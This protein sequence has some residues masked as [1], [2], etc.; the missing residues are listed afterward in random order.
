MRVLIQCHPHATPKWEVSMGYTM[1]VRTSNDPMVV[2]CEASDRDELYGQMQD[3]S[4]GARLAIGLKQR[5]D[6]LNPLPCQKLLSGDGHRTNDL[7]TEDITVLDN[8]LDFG[9]LMRDGHDKVLRPDG[10]LAVG[11]DVGP[12]DGSIGDLYGDVGVAGHG[13]AGHLAAD[14][15]G[16]ARA[17]ELAD[18]LG[19]HV[20]VGQVA[21]VVHPDVE[22][23]VEQH[24]LE[25]RP[26][27]PAV[28]RPSPG[29][30]GGHHLHPAA[31]AA[32]APRGR[33]VGHHLRPAAREGGRGRGH[34]GRRRVVVAV[35]E[36]H[37][38][39]DILDGVGR[40]GRGGFGRG[41][42]GFRRGGV[43]V[44]EAGAR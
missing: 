38:G 20:L 41:G 26:E 29:R 13:R 34:G 12:R 8:K 1:T 11:D 5:V 22:G 32:P 9:G 30:A 3:S 35:G 24:H 16:D 43:L 14:G 17:E 25:R 28:L 18:P 6:T 4:R 23:A 31:V 10:V 37:G 19:E 21:G 36:A 39:E 33:A 7:S 40:R 27:A 15:A 2:H 44:M 42:G